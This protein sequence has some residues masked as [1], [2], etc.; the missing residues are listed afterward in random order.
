LKITT[1]DQFIDISHKL[2][3]LTLKIPKPFIKEKTESE[4]ITE[5]RTLNLYVAFE[6]APS[7]SEQN[8][9]DADENAPTEMKMKPKLEVE[10]EQL[11]DIL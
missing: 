10:C 3:H 7:I 4:F 8:E 2:Y 5:S 1:A 6:P 11:Y 9:A